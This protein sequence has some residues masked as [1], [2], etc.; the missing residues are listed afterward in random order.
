MLR[1]AKQRGDRSATAG[2]GAEGT[3][4]G[5]GGG[6]FDLTGPATLTTERH[7]GQVWL[8]AVSAQGIEMLAC[9]SDDTCAKR[10]RDILTQSIAA[11]HAAGSLGI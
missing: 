10:F 6:G 3:D 5:Y 11:A 4:L 2:E 7:N 1:Q 8:C 9:F